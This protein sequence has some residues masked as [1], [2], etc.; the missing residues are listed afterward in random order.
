[1]ERFRFDYDF[2]WHTS[3][4]GTFEYQADSNTLRLLPPFTKGKNSLSLVRVLLSFCLGNYKARKIVVVSYPHLPESLLLAVLLFVLKPF[5]VTVVVDVQDLALPREVPWTISY[6]VWWIVNEFFYFYAFF[7]LNATEC[8]KLYARR[9]RG[10]TIVI[11]MA[12]HHNIIT[13]KSSAIVRNGLTLAYVGSVE[14][15]RGFP[16]L[17]EIVKNLREEGFA[18]DLVINGNLETIAPNAYPWLRLYER[19]SLES[20]SELLRSVDVGVITYVDK[21]YWGLV[22]ITKMTTYMAA[23]LPILSLRLTETS[24]ILAKWECGI[25]VDDWDGFAAAIKTFCE[26]KLLRERLGKNARRAAVE[27]YNWAKQV[28]RLGEFVEKLQN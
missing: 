21:D 8:E 22:S 26:D 11:P 1:M 2:Y 3:D 19:Q 6:L 5:R 7:I 23:G 25:S 15:R 10:R 18:V 27:E 20:F 14:K 28:E 13:P 12:A 9:A 16:D 17:I 4:D 24:R